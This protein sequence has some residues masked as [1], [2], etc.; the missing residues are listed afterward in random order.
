MKHNGKVKKQFGHSRRQKLNKDSKT[1]SLQ[2]ITE[3]RLNRSG[4]QKIE[5]S[6]L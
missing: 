6:N 1:D 5:D 2:G 3:S 4:S